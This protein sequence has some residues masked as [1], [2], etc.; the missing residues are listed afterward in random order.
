[1]SC[2][3][4][5]AEVT[6]PSGKKH[7]PKLEDN[8]DKTVRIGYVPT[9][10]GPHRLDVTYNKQPVYG[11]PFH[12]YVHSLLRGNVIAYGPGLSHGIVRRPCDFTIITKDANAGEMHIV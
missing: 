5:T 1:M 3:L 2:F 4:S 10:I 12:F 8:H 7:S 11:N 6:T 9:E